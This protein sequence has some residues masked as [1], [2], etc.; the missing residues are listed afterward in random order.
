MTQK[1]LDNNFKGLKWLK[2]ELFQNDA[3]VPRYILNI[4]KLRQGSGKDGQGW[5]RMA[6]KVKSFKAL[7]P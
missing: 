6:L 4:V 5:A 1:L 7:N 2:S 3:D